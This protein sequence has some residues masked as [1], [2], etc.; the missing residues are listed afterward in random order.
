MV[1]GSGN[2]FAPSKGSFPVPVDA[3]TVDPDDGEQVTVCFSVD[4]LPFVV[5][6]LQQLALQATWTGDDTAV[7]LAQDRAQTLIAMFGAPDGGCE[8][9]I[10]IPGLIYDPDT[11]TVKQTLDGGATYF[12]NPAADPR[13][14]VSFIFPSDGGTDAPCG[15]ASNMTRW[16]KNLIDEV[17]IIVDVAG[18]A[19]GLVALVLGLTVELGPFGLL[20]DLVF[21]LCFLLFSTGATAIAAAMTSTVYDDLTC[22]F[23]CGIGDDG[24][25]TA[26]QLGLIK[27]A[28]D[29]QIGG[30]AAL[31]LQGMLLLMGENG[32]AN[33]G[34][35]GDDPSPNCSGCPSCDWIVEYDFATGMHGWEV[36][37][38]SGQ[39][40]G[41][42]VG[43]HWQATL[44][45]GQLNL[46]LIKFMVG[47]EVSQVSAYEAC[48]HGSGIGHGQRQFNMGTN[49]PFAGTANETAALSTKDPAGWVIIHDHAFTTTDGIGM[50]WFADTNGTGNI[51]VYKI[52]ISGTGT[53]P[54]DGVPV[55]SLT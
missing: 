44:S 49:N 52:R 8:T 13:R 10:S 37:F 2:P 1:Y 43:D 55:G 17:L 40:R 39:V 7:L 45:G 32:L 6:S 19:G 35:V 53:P 47:V 26:A 18:D 51:A 34:V 11:D 48:F 33:A 25:V 4:W 50:D 29:D 31:I 14:G 41:G 38:N 24:S 54:P 16:M 27:A 23:F 22:I 5:G 15:A 46:F 12:D 20:I 21:G 30:T 36:F 3:P 28:I 9:G 42:F